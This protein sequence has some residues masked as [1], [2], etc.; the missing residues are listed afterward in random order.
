MPYRIE[1]KGRG[2]V[3]KN[4]QTGKEY[5]KKGIPRAKAEAQ[6]RVLEMVSKME[7]KK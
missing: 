4:V 6:K 5:S 1:E 2:Y 3:V 7:K